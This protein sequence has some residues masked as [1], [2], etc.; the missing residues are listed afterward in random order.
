[1]VEGGA[2]LVT[3]YPSF[4][5]RH[6]ARRLAE[7]GRKVYLLCREKF[8]DRAWQDL[9]DLGSKVKL[10][11]GDVVAMDLGLSGKEVR[12][13]RTAV[14]DMYHLA[15]F[16]YLSS[17][18]REMDQVNV[19]GTRNALAFAK[20]LPGL[21]RF[22]HYSSAFVSGNREGVIMEDEL[23]EPDKYRNSFE[24]SKF[25]AERLAQ[26]ARQDMPVTIV[27]P[28]LIVGDSRTGEMDRYE[29]PNSIIY[30]LAKLPVSMSLPLPGHGG[31]PLNLVPVDYVAD[32]MVHLAS[33]PTTVGKT[34]HLVDTNPLPASKVFELVCSAADR[35]PPKRSI[36]LNLASALLKMP[37]IERHW[38]SP[39]LFID[40]MNQLVIYNSINTTEALAGTGIKCP[41][42]P[43]YVKH[44]VAYLKR[45]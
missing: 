9:A 7:G 39:R 13:L 11:T 4:V 3:G 17:G 25:L 33:L 18:D 38:R 15:G 2:A 19:E 30:V 41:P 22:L 16:Y 29:G 44:L 36:P 5:V 1:M 34:Y 28:S 42:F 43:S 14:R 20:D 35:R 6:L 24:R 21:K 26:E 32:A 23:I 8:E 37:G 27:R 45:K 31:Y 10:V 40:L 12:E